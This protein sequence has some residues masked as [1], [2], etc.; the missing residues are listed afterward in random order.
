MELIPIEVECHA[1]YKAD[2]Y[3]KCFYREDEKFDIQEITDRWYQGDT[4]PVWP[5]SN[6]FKV[7]TTS[8][9]KYIIKHDLE[10]DK[11]YICV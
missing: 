5:V 4:N 8:G 6:Y 11:W 3:P 7:L 2:E 9:E 1:G 10:S